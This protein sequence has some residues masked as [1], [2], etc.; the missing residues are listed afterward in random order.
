MIKPKTP[1]EISSMREGGKRIGAVLRQLLDMSLPGVS[2]LTIEEAAQEGI[3]KAGGTPSFMTVGD[4]KWA[5]CLC[6]NDE[7]VH[8]IPTKRKLADGDVFTIDIGMIFDGLH[9]DTAY[10]KY[11]SFSSYVPDVIEKFLS[12]GEQTLERAIAQ[13]K[14]GNRIG[15]ISSAIEQGIEPAGY[16]VVRTLVGHGVGKALHEEPQI[17]GLLRTDISRTP[18]LTTG[19]TIAIEVIYGEGTGSVV[20]ANDDGWTISTRDVSMSAVFEHSVVVGEA[21]GQILTVRP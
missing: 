16:H 11:I 21:G 9:T 10:S 13:A 6:I 19:M 18:L 8:G 15:H 17:P 7:V 1:E 4:Y 3:R 5:T 2:L 12:T 20:Y 14:N